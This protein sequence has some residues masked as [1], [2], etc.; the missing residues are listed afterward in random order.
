MK[1]EQ[2][3]NPVPQMQEPEEVKPM[4]VKKYTVLWGATQYEK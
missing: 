4:M 3:L 1:N 2:L